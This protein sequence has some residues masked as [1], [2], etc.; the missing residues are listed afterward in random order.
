MKSDSVTRYSTSARRV[1]ELCISRSSISSGVPPPLAASR[2]HPR[3]AAAADAADTRRSGWPALVLRERALHV[4]REVPR[5]GRGLAHDGVL[6]RRFMASSL[7]SFC[8]A[9]C[10]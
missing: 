9:A 2:R 8:P 4:P 5:L 6:A 7:P 3:A 1:R 10:A